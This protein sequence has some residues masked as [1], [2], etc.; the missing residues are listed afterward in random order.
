[1]DIHR[2]FASNVVVIRLAVEEVELTAFYRSSTTSDIIPT[3]MF[4]TNVRYFM[5]WERN[6]SAPTVQGIGFLLW[7]GG[8]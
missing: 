5:M 8:L 3:A 2:M 1:M 6:I 7:F 4:A